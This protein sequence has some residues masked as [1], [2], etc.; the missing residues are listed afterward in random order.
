[1]FYGFSIFIF[2]S[3]RLVGCLKEHDMWLWSE[4]IDKMFGGLLSSR[5]ILN[6]KRLLV[7]EYN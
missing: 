4:W 2:R 3:S 6:M 1:M 7:Q 5:W